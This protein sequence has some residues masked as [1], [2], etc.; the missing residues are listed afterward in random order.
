MGWSPSAIF[1]TC[2][3]CSP[4][5]RSPASSS[6]P[7][8]TSSRLSSRKKLSGASQK[9][10]SVALSWLSLAEL[11]TAHRLYAGSSRPVRTRLP[12]R[13][14]TFDAQ[15]LSEQTWLA[16][17]YIV[18]G[19]R[20]FRLDLAEKVAALFARGASERQALQCLARD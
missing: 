13:I 5:G 14:P 10:R 16:L 18:L 20:A 9:T 7:P 19:R 2:S 3:T 1:A 8:P 4:T 11:V 12:E 17:G 15:H 6:S